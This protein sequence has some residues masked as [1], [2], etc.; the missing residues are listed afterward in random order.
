[1]KKIVAVPQK[2]VI[3]RDEILSN[4]TDRLQPI[5]TATGLHIDIERTIERAEWNWDAKTPIQY[6]YFDHGDYRLYVAADISERCGR[7]DV[8]DKL[9]PHRYEWIASEQYRRRHFPD[10]PWD[11]FT[12]QNA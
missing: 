9:C 6:W 12:D 11:V 5:A 1:M 2:D 8:W 3:G 7:V 10:L 4:I